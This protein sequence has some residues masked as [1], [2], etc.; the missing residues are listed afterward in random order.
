MKE[1]LS[2][3]LADAEARSLVMHA[4]YE[5]VGSLLQA[6]RLV[7]S[8]EFTDKNDFSDGCHMQAL[9]LSFMIL[10]TSLSKKSMRCQ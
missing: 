1:I 10:H 6:A 7:Q 9:S 8:V 5:F 3:L 2:H 4:P